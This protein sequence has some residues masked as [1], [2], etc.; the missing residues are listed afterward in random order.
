MNV[1]DR[2]VGNPWCPVMAVTLY[3]LFIV[4]GKSYFAD[5][6]AWDWRKTMAI[7]NLGLSVFSAI[8]FVR[9]A[10]QLFHNLIN[11]TLTENLCFDPESH[12]GSGPTGFWVQMF[13][14]SKF[15]Y[16]LNRSR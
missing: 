10:P 6:P 14:L 4:L 2:M 12:Y 3:G 13:I 1:R 5:R 7:W 16:V 15:P 9:T 8:G 11:Y